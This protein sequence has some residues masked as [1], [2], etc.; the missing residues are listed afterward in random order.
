MTIVTF[1]TSE[2]VNFS[3]CGALAHPCSHDDDGTRAVCACAQ[4]ELYEPR[5]AACAKHC[6]DHRY[7]RIAR[8]QSLDGTALIA[9]VHDAYNEEEAAFNA[10]AY[11]RKMLRMHG[12][13]LVDAAFWLHECA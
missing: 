12:I 6:H 7:V 5:I 11:L 2:K 10:S 13:C 3:N 8:D 1:D 9:A 4:P